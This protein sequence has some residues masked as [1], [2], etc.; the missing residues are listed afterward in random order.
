MIKFKSN[1]NFLFRL[2]KGIQYFYK[3][4]DYELTDED[5]KQVKNMQERKWIKLSNKAFFPKREENELPAQN[6]TDE[7][8]KKVSKDAEKSN[9]KKIKKAEKKK[10]DK[11]KPKK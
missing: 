11:E 8:D 5:T 4:R 3:G 6:K 10:K 1:A 2:T 7:L 9:D